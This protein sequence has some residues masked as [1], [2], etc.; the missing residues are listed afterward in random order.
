MTDIDTD[1][2]SEWFVLRCLAAGFLT[3]DV[4]VSGQNQYRSRSV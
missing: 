4:N 1:V 3:V 2:D